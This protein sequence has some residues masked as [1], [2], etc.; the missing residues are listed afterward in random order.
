MFFS[1]LF[2]DVDVVER[3]GLNLKE[4]GYV[5]VSCILLV[6]DRGMLTFLISAV[7]NAGT[8]SQ[9]MSWRGQ[10]LWSINIQNGYTFLV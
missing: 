1:F 10:R 6:E 9:G 8:N 2:R 3:P 5:D 4:T 7:M